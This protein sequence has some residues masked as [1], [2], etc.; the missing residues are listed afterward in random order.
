[1]RPSRTDPQDSLMIFIDGVHKGFVEAVRITWSAQQR[2]ERTRRAAK[3]IGTRCMQTR[4]DISFT[5]GTQRNQPVF[6]EALEIIR[7]IPVTDENATFP[8][9][10]KQ[11]VALR[12]KPEGLTYVLNRC[13]DSA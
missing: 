3:K 9:E 11:P 12:S 10:S 1:E 6:G 2:Y 7:M 4:P 5:I 13:H 8:I